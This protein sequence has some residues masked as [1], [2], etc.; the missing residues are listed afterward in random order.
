VT[1]ESVDATVPEFC[2][3]SSERLQFRLQHLVVLTAVIAVMLAISGPRDI[4]GIE[5]PHLV[6]L[7]FTGFG[8]IY[9]VLASVAITIV[10]YGVAWHR[11]GQSFF[12][13]PGHWL[14]VAIAANQLLVFIE[15]LTMRV[16]AA[17]QGTSIEA[18]WTQLPSGTTW[19][20]PGIALL[21]LNTYI[22]RRKCA[23]ARWSRVF[24]ANAATALVP[25]IGEL[26]VLLFLERAVRAE[27]SR[28]PVSARWRQSRG[29]E[30]MVGGQ[31]VARPRDPAHWCGVAI[32]FFMSGTMVLVVIGVVG[33]IIL[34]V[35]FT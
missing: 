33:Y 32:T 4:R 23:E 31:V 7:A 3:T 34:P 2:D 35:F 10:A 24:Y 5:V 22:G 11:H 29:V 25:V 27:R 16:L 1:D 13:E 15:I 21:I 20:I 9:T 18:V 19:L 30:P 26:L 6:Q 14:L 12:D 28:R 17:I 8:I